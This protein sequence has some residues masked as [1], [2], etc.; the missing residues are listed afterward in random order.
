MDYEAA[1]PYTND[2]DGFC[3]IAVYRNRSVFVLVSGQRRTPSRL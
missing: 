2:N 3:N 1:T